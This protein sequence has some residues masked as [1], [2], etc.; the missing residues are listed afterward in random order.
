MEV[1]RLFKLNAKADIA[2]ISGVLRVTIEHGA[3]VLRLVF[4]LAIF[5]WVASEVI[6]GWTRVAPL[7]KVLFALTTV[8]AVADFAYQL[9][10]S[11]ILEFGPEGLKIQRNYFGWEYIRSYAIDKCGELS[12]QPEDSREGEFALNCRVGWRKVQF[13]KYLN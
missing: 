9:T 10:G 12:W 4:D 5:I 7:S 1:A 8:G 13:G 6:E 3:N 2:F 11:E